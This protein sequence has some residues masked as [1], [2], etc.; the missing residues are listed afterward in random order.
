MVKRLAEESGVPHRTL[1]WQESKPGTGLQEAAREARYRL[2]ARAARE[3][4]AAHIVTAHTLD[5][6]AETVLMR[7]ARGSGIAGL[8]AM[9]RLSP[10]PADESGALRLVRP[11]LVLPKT[12]LLA[13][14]RAA[15]I[16]YAEDSSNSDPRFTR[17]RFR[18]ALP[19]LASE[20]LSTER[21]AILARRV[22]RADAALE[23][24]TDAACRLLSLSGWPAGGPIRLD[25]PRFFG[26]PAE[27]S[28]RVLARAIAAV[29]HE[30]P[31]Q[32]AKL[33]TLWAAMPKSGGI[34]FRR[35]LAGAV[36]TRAAA[37]VTVESAPPRR[38]KKPA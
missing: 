14:L 13:T 31:V 35:S 32:L 27:I 30:G 19:L 8:S 3:E 12:R 24:A 28:L 5:D 34:R 17:A 1:R 21:L 18:H 23:V 10:L 16:P 7:L 22:R 11:F 4:G 2:L 37:L 9:T 29:G 15:G 6:Q 26:L 25:A 38:K 33:E 36:V 20:G